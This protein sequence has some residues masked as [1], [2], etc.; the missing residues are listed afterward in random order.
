[1]R[2]GVPNGDELDEVVEGIDDG[3]N[4]E[5]VW[6]HS[7]GRDVFFLFREDDDNGDV[8]F[9]FGRNTNHRF[10]MGYEVLERLVV[11]YTDAGWFP[12]GS[13]HGACEERVLGSLGRWLCEEADIQ[14]NIASYLA[15]YLVHQG[16]AEYR[17]QGRRGELRIL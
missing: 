3:V 14:I 17:R 1:M 8:E 15:G 12:I 16:R 10:T 13:K 9:W 4:A 2:C 6:I 7:L 5:F 11:D